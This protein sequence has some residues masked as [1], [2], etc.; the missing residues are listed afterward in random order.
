MSDELNGITPETVAALFCATVEPMAVLLTISA[1]G[2]DTPI[3]VTDHPGRLPG[4][5]R[6]GLASRGVTYDFFPF[7][8]QWSGGGGGDLAR[9][10]Q[11]VIGNTAGEIAA[12]LEQVAEQPELTIEVVRVAAPDVVERAMT[13]ATLASAEEDGPSIKGTINPRRFDVEPACA[14]SYLPA[15]APA[16]F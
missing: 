5:A 9:A 2:L 13:G 6:Q 1:A 8:L 7:S 11:I 12:A 3:T 15:L 14:K 10:A 16:L 4:L